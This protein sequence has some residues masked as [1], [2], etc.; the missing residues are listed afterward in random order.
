[1]VS[2]T[3]EARLAGSAGSEETQKGASVA[4]G[5]FHGVC[6]GPKRPLCVCA[7]VRTISLGRW[8]IGRPVPVARQSRLALRQTRPINLML[9]EKE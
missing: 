4:G 7:V 2:F 5:Q 1:M 9:K 6:F 3:R 8:M